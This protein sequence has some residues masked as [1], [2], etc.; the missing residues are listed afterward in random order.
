MTLL[1]DLV[2]CERREADIKLKIVLIVEPGAFEMIEFE[3]RAVW[4][5][6]AHRPLAVRRVFLFSPRVGVGGNTVLK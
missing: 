4:Q 3:V 6:R 1:L 2:S 5:A